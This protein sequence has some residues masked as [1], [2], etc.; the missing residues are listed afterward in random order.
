M[1]AAKL[2]TP[3]VGVEGVLRLGGH[4]A[5]YPS[6]PGEEAGRGG[7]FRADG[8][9]RANCR[10][11]S[12]VRTGAGEE[13]RLRPDSRSGVDEA[14]PATESRGRERE[15][16]KGVTGR[17][18]RPRFPEGPGGWISPAKLGLLSVPYPTATPNGVTPQGSPSHPS[19]KGVM[20][21]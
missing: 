7:A 4:R 12:C 19:L 13:G 5:G 20:Q 21:L 15:R 8:A 14:R 3:S 18:W 11:S 16:L 10:V 1:N 6:R 17:F 2:P 9:G